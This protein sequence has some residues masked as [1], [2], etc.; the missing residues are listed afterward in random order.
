MAERS[1]VIRGILRGQV[2]RAAYTLLLRNLLPAYEAM[3]A[4]LERHRSSP[5]PGGL[6]R[7]EVYRA[8]S[9]ADDLTALAGADWREAVP[10]LQQGRDYAARV[11][12]A[13]AGDGRLLVPHAY[14]RYLGDLNGGQVLKR[15]VARALGLGGEALTFYEFPAISDLVAFRTA[16]RA[17]VDRAGQQAVQLEPLVAEAA[18]AFR[19]NIALSEAVAGFR[20]S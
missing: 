7:G 9:L 19:L 20:P 5:L 13:A 6:A 1:G 12:A 11:A 4:G 15:L 16:Y 10:V 17:A 14:V 8:A 3:E 18:E 2:E